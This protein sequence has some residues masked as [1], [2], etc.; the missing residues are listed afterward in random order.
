MD[1]AQRRIFDRYRKKLGLK[2]EQANPLARDETLRTLFEAGLEHGAAPVT[3]ANLILNEVARELKNFSLGELRYG[4]EALAELA[5]MIDDERISVKIAKQVFEEMSKSGES[6]AS[7]VEAKGW[8][9]I[10]D[11]KA[12]RPVIEEVLEK[13]PENV[14][15]YRE[16]NQKLFGFFVGQVLKATGGKA[17]PRLVNELLIQALG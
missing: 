15:K 14:V 5:T 4:P 3:L 13:N 6:P 11:P 9:Q 16:G 1:E 12:I 2:E 8:E 10:S 7:I 17:N